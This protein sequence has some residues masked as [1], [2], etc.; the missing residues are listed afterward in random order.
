MILH[1]QG[2]IQEACAE[3]EKSLAVDP[4]NLEMKVLFE[5]AVAAFSILC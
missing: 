1:Y 3:Y 2:R 5:H 4:S